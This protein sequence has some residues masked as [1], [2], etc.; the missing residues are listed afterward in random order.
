VELYCALI[1]ANSEH[2]GQKKELHSR[3]CAFHDETGNGHPPASAAS[4]SFRMPWES[5]RGSIIHRA[6]GTASSP[7]PS[8]I[9]S[10]EGNVK[11]LISLKRRRTL[12]LFEVSVTIPFSAPHSRDC[13]VC[14]ERRAANR[15][16]GGSLF[17]SSSARASW[18]L[19]RVRIDRQVEASRW[20]NVRAGTVDGAGSSVGNIRMGKSFGRCSFGIRESSQKVSGLSEEN[21]ACALRRSAGPPILFT[22]VANRSLASSVVQNSK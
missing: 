8:W 15:V 14:A 7:A 4:A 20:W 13:T 22:I 10:T 21:S 11:P 16:G 17:P 5:D 12:V 19:G 2:F 3:T 6:I 18:R 9:S 1:Q